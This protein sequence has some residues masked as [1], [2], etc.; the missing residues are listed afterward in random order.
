MLILNH[1][2]KDYYDGVVGTTG[3]DK[4]I[5][6]NR[7]VIELDEKERPKIFHPVGHSFKFQKENGFVNL[8]N[9]GIKSEFSKEI[10]AYS[11]FIIGF[12]GKVYIGWK[13]YNIVNKLFDVKITYDLDYM[14]SV[15]KPSDYRGNFMEDVDYIQNYNAI[16]LFRELNAPIFVYDSDYKRTEIYGRG[17]SKFFVNPNLGEYEFYKIFDAFQAFQ[18]IQMFIGGV[19]GTG[20]KEIVEVAD[21]YKIQQYGF[22]KWSFRKEKETKK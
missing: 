13:I 16:K 21:K 11:Y 6:Y 19:L 10:Q 20:E 17:N 2:K 1:K 9:Y 7:D 22:D 14:K 4:T 18:E 5:V 12:C 8:N 15:L 3:V